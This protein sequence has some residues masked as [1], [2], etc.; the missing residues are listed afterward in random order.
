MK[1]IFLILIS[2]L[3]FSCSAFKNNPN[4]LKKLNQESIKDLNGTYSIFAF[5]KLKTEYPYFNNVNNI[6]YRKYGRG[7]R[8]TIRFDTIS[9][10][11]CKIKVINDKK[12]RIDFVKKTDKVKH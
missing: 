5:D 8:D 4:N 10:G 9:G 3:F 12:L 6:F 1:R 11:K 2:L 7:Q